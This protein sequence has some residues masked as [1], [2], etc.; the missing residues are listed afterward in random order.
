MGRNLVMPKLSDS[1]EESVIVKWL[2]Q[3]GDSFAAGEA[4]AEIETDKAT[5][6][7]E[8]ESDGVLA[9]IVVE[10]GGAARPGEPIATIDGEGD[11]PSA[12]PAPEAATPV[13]T[14]DGRRIDFRT[15]VREALDESLAADERVVLFGEDVAVA[16]GVFAVTPGLYEKYGPDRVFDTPISEL[17]LAGAAFGSAVTGLRPVVEIMF[18]DFLPLVM[19]SIVNQMSKYWFLTGGEVS[20]PVV[21]RSVV[22]GGGRFGAIHS[23]TPASWFMGIPGIKIVAPSMPGDARA[24][25]RAAIEDDNPVLFFEHKRLYGVEGEADG[26]SAVIGEAAIVRDGRDVTL[27]SAM[28]GVHECLAAAG[29]L[30][31]RGI[32][33]EVVDLRTLRP[34]DAKTVLASL[35]RTNRLVVV[36]EGPLTG[37][38]AGEVLSL[39]VEQGL[40]DIDDAWRIT[41]PDSP[42]PYSPPL[43]DAHLPGAERIVA[44]VE[45]RLR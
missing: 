1:N 38:W 17:A 10:E 42:I 13:R 19:D 27:V 21:I 9:T 15:A 31:G 22:G 26:A 2:K 29:T 6:I 23:Q 4:L 30:A 14:G 12:P 45:R 25:L 41:S 32:E 18:G 35:A 5:V 3:A 40:G 28:R 11:A 7:Y 16:G 33:A 24:L 44:E 8:A 37:G 36:E 20:V 43:E 34:L 39:A